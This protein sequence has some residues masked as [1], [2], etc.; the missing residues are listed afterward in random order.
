MLI[1][2]AWVS[3]TIGPT[4]AT[5]PLPATNDSTKE[6][7]Q[8]TVKGKTEH[9]GTILKND[10]A[11]E[12]PRLRLF[13]TDNTVFGPPIQQTFA[14][15]LDSII[16]INPGLR[17]PFLRELLIPSGASLNN[18]STSPSAR[19]NRELEQYSKFT[20]FERMCL[21]AKRYALYNSS[22]R[23]LKSYQLEIRRTLRW[24]FEEV[25]K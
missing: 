22:D 21:I 5:Q 10:W 9:P 13:T 4:L 19:F 8:D 25:F 18:L 7:R 23:S 17:N 2:F 16:K 14:T 20:S 3:I 11:Q 12:K 6:Q 15:A 1:L 24:W